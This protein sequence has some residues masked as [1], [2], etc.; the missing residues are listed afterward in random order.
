MGVVV[1]PTGR[2]AEHLIGFP[3]YLGYDL[4]AVQPAFA[5]MPLRSIPFQ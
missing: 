4:G 3:A 5:V 1:K 2:I